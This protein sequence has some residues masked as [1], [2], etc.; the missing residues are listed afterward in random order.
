MHQHPDIF[1]V[2]RDR[3]SAYASAASEA[4]P[5]ALQFVD[6]FHLVKNLTEATQVLLARCQAEIREASKQKDVDHVE[7]TQHVVPIEEWRPFE[8][9]HVEKLRLARRA[10]RY[11][12]YRQVN[13]DSA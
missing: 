2:S 8:P 9:A 1:V 7:P 5:Q 12:R 11:E 3:A 10:G 6:R 4:A 13:E